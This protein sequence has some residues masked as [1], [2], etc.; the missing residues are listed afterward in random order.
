MSCAF[1]CSFIP[2]FARRNGRTVTV[3]VWRSARASYWPQT[4]EGGKWRQ[5]LM[6]TEV[7]KTAPSRHEK[8]ATVLPSL[9]GPPS[10]DERHRPGLGLGQ[11]TDESA[12][13]L[14]PT[15]THLGG[16]GHQASSSVAPH[17]QD[18]FAPSVDE[19]EPLPHHRDRRTDG[20]V[21]QPHGWRTRAWCRSPIGHH[22]SVASHQ[23]R[24]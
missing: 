20:E 14:R 23:Q 22:L 19:P 21:P 2:F 6:T 13:F 9:T 8:G 17:V 3:T 10:Q 12:G 11:L 7:Q 5:A 4:S 24:P 18:R 1:S 15:P 16:Q